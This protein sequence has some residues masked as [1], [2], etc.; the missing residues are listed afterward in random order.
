MPTIRVNMNGLPAYLTFGGKYKP[1]DP[2]PSG[3]LDWHEWA[4]VQHKA[5]LRQKRCGRCGLWQFPQE[6]SELIDVSEARTG[7]GAN[8]GGG[9]VVT[10]RSPVCLECARKAADQ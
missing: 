1:G 7:R 9:R 3:Y 8:R 5:G 6:M 2:P 10:L 4:D